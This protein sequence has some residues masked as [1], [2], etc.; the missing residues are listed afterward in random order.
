MLALS[1]LYTHMCCCL[2][3]LLPFYGHA[4]GA[5]HLPSSTWSL[6]RHSGLFACL[7]PLMVLCLFMGPLCLWIKS[8]P[9]TWWTKVL[10]SPQALLSL[11]FHHWHMPCCGPVLLPEHPA[12]TPTSVSSPTSLLG[13][14]CVTCLPRFIRISG[15][16]P[17][18]QCPSSVRTSHFF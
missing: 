4:A 13:R 7:A 18:P 12:H 2:S 3:L 17:H 11:P 1:L 14:L 5:L 6:H 15:S 16:S 8:V 10:S 9:L